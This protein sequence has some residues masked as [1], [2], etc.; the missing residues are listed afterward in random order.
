MKII[1]MGDKR[2]RQKKYPSSIKKPKSIASSPNRK[3][4]WKVS[5]IDD[6]FK[7]GW[8]QITCPC[9]LKNIW[10][11]MHNFETMTWEEILGPNNHAISIDDITKDAKE[12]LRK[13][14]HDDE[15]TLVSFRITGEQ[16]IWAIRSQDDAFLLWWDPKHEICPSNMRYT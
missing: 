1:K 5:K 11:K 2:S 14:E 12:R 7:W 13:L 10:E 8:N 16:R 6:N 4:V 15:E 9:F 3:L